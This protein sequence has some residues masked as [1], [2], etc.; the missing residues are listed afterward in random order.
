VAANQSSEA[1]FSGQF[2]MEWV[3]LR[4]EQ[5]NGSEYGTARDVGRKK[6]FGANR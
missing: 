5:A 1:R 2:R 3:L 4:Q 6:E